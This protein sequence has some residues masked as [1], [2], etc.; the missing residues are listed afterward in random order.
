[1][2]ES[3]FNSKKHVT[4]IDDETYN[5]LLQDL[6]EGKYRALFFFEYDF[7]PEKLKNYGLQPKNDI[8]LGYKWRFFNELCKNGAVNKYHYTRLKKS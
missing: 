7:D 4:F 2:N 3:A 5:K 6:E 1:M 8:N